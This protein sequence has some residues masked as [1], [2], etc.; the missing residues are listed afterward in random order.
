MPLPLVPALILG[1]AVAAGGKGA[2]DSWMAHSARRGA[3]KSR[4][5]AEATLEAAVAHTQAAHQVTTHKLARL[6]DVQLQA[7]AMLEEAVA[8]LERGNVR[9]SSFTD[10]PAPSNLELEGWTATGRDA[11]SALGGILASATAGTAARQV[12]KVVAIRVGK[13]STG[14]ALSGLSGAAARNATL[15]W[16]G[17]GSL[18]AG[19]GGM[20]LGAMVL[21]SLN[22][23]GVLLGVGMTA[24]KVVASY[25]A[26]VADAVGIMQEEVARLHGVDRSMSLVQR[27]ATQLRRA[28]NAVAHALRKALD[29]GHSSQMRDVMTVVGLSRAL[30][31]LS[32]YDLGVEANASTEAWHDPYRQLGP[33][34]LHPDDVDFGAPVSDTPEESP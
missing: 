20:A 9:N 1:S 28:T 25:E 19:G 32:R 15:A 22:V 11:S 8:W 24:R 18:A 33:L 4:A 2:F 5:E 31:T 10:V 21:S 14:A 23:G 16:L 27:R 17:G 30:G 26:D 13:A 6:I 34:G 29:D 3:S 7:L 12:A